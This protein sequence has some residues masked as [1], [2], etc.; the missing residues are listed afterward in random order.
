MRDADTLMRDAATSRRGTASAALLTRLGGEYGIPVRKCLQG[1][2]LTTAALE[3]PEAEISAAQELALITNLVGELGE[4][5]GLGLEAGRRYHLTTFGLLGLATLSSPTLGGAVDLGMR[6]LDLTFV[7]SAF[8]REPVR[9]GLRMVIDDRAMRTAFGEPIARFLAER[10]MAAVVTA[11]RDLLGPDR[12]LD[13][14]AFRHNAPPHTD[15]HPEI[16]GVRPEFGSDTTYGVIGEAILSTPLPQADPAA[17]ELG[18]RHCERQLLARRSVHRLGDQIRADLSRHLEQGDGAA[19]QTQTAA[20]LNMSERSL[21]RRLRAEGVRYS[22]LA[23]QAAA[24]AA[25]A[26]LA[27]G[28]TVANVAAVLGYADSSSFTHA[29]KQWTGTSPGAYARAAQATART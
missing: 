8:R 21:R 3:D 19:T 10:E 4:V 28:R 9:G 24:C 17:A 22:D 12:T 25:R 2:G 16:L 13:R 5:P 18:R 11:V 26:L 29:F 7:F 1:T 23:A 14:V 27:D 15:R 20:R 6:H